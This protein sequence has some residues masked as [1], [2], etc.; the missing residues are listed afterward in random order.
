MHI[1]IRGMR[2]SAVAVAWLGRLRRAAGFGLGVG[3]VALGATL[4][5]PAQAQ[6]SAISQATQDLSCV[7][8]RYAAANGGKVP[9]CTAGEFNA[10]A[11]VEQPPG[12]ISSCAAGSTIE[13]SIITDMSGTNADR[14]SGGMY[15]GQAGN[16]PRA[17]TAP[18]AAVCSVARFP[19]SS[20]PVPGYPGTGTGFFA[21]TLAGN[22]AGSYHAGG[23]ERWQI[24]NVKVRCEAGPNGTLAIPYML[25]YSQGQL[26]VA[27]D[28]SPNLIPGT[29]AKCNA[30]TVTLKAPDGGDVKVM[31][32]VE[33]TKATSPAGAPDSFAFTAAGT[34][35]DTPSFS[36]THGQTQKVQ[37][38]LT[39]GTSTLT[40]SEALTGGWNPNATITCTAPGGGS[41]ASY[42][43]V[44]NAHRT[45]TAHLSN[46]H[47][48][49]Q[50]TITNTQL[51]MATL[52]LV[53]AMD[54]TYPG[55]A[56]PANFTLTAT[57][58]AT[59]LSGSGGASGVVP[60]G[61]YTLAESGPSG[62]TPSAWSC[63]GGALSG[64]QL[65]LSQDQNITC[66]IT[67]RHREADLQI[68]K[69]PKNGSATPGNQVVW[70]IIAQNNGP[71][72]VIGATIT[73]TLPAGIASATVA[74]VGTGGAS[75]YSAAGSGNIADT[76]N[77][78]AGS[79]VT[80]TVTANIK[81]GETANL[82]NTAVIGAPADPADPNPTNNSDTSTITLNPSADLRITK[83]QATPNPAIPGEELTWTITV[84]NLGKSSAANVTTSD[85]VDSNVTGLA[86]GGAYAGNCS[87][88]GQNVSCSF[89]TL[90]PNETRSY[91]I[92]GT[93]SASFTG[94]LGNT[95]TASST[96]P[97]PDTA[98]NTSTSTTPTN[99][100]SLIVKKVIN[101]G[102]SQVVK[103]STV[104]YA[105]SIENKGGAAAT[106]AWT[107][108]PSG[109]TITGIS[110]SITCNLSGCSNVTV[111][112]NAT[113]NFTV[114]ATVT[115]NAGDDA[116]NIARVT[117]GGCTLQNPCTAEDRKPIVAPNVQV[118]KST[119]VI[120]SVNTPASGNQYTAAYT[121]TVTNSGT[122]DGTYTLSDTPAFPSG[123]T[124]NSWQVTTNGGTLNSLMPG[125]TGGQISAANVSIA[126][127]NTTHTYAVQITFT[128]SLAATNLSCTG[129]A[130]NGA[131]NAV[132]LSGGSTGSTT[133]CGPVPA[134]VNLTLGKSASVTQAANGDS[135]TYSLT[136][137]N[138]GPVATTNP[139]T[140]VDTIPAGITVTAVTNG[141]GFSCTPSSSLP[142]VGNGVDTAI[143]CTST[144]GVA[145]GVSNAVVATLS[146]T[147]TNTQDITNRIMATSGDPRCVGVSNPCTASV[148]VQ[149]ISKPNLTVS[150][151]APAI[152]ST[153]AGGN[154]Y[155]A[156]YIVTV[157][158]TGTADGK[159]TLTDAASFATGTTLNAWAVAVVTDADPDKVGTAITPASGSGAP[160]QV[161]AN[162]VTLKAGKTHKYSVAVTFTV[163]A[164][165]MEADRVCAS[166]FEA[167]KG[168]FNTAT[169]R[170]TLTDP[171]GTNQSASGNACGD[172]PKALNLTL[173][174]TASVTEA[175]NGST[176]AYTLSASNS[177]GSA[178]TN[179]TTIVDTI[180]V[181]ITVTAV[182]NGA[183]FVCT[184]SSSLPLVGN[185][186]GTTISCVSSTGVA[187]GA[188][189]VT[190]ATLSATK[191]NTLDIT[192]HVKAT[193]GDP[194]CTGSPN[195]CT[196]S[197]EVK[198]SSAPQ[199]MVTKSNGAS[200]VTVGATVTY[201]V[202]IANSGTKDATGVTWADSAN[203]SLSVQSIAKGPVTGVGSD[204][205]SCSGVSCSGIAVAV[206]G[207]VSYTVT[208]KVTGKVGDD[209]QNTANVIGGGCTAGSEG[210]PSTPANCTST[211]TDKIVAPVA[212]APIPT[213]NE[214]AL[215]LL[216]T[217]LGLMGWRSSRRFG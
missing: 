200:N 151:A 52:T 208:A 190:V 48:G 212:V 20:V 127:N 191:T 111:P 115:G 172:L 139:T 33:V 159:Y 142:L 204:G 104:T 81:P 76:V 21:P 178:T 177:G 107:D 59:V 47:I 31:G 80:Y 187:A 138:S 175:A 141:V 150:K 88:V 105:V 75:G 26:V 171:L 40:I 34:G 85:A 96:T 154:Q 131:F 38:P 209:A 184:P 24:R 176:F 3:A 108:S 86:V 169:I 167:N 36:L 130:S 114:T 179:P 189:G 32:W 5:L 170:G 29:S 133:A 94:D 51:P 63:P 25:T 18:P 181:G 87:V 143:S 62:Y 206:N 45:I 128:T 64:N 56:I 185:G 122:A 148:P 101:G 155:T 12:G 123:V 213:L 194:R 109:L 201:T 71:D 53:K 210:A 9:N 15:F 126:K 68:T 199:L 198:D 137:S 197:V 95:A 112:A 49:A 211:D 78:P 55:S 43:T 60:P 149:D 153:V 28:A 44:D 182:A 146:V 164:T 6:Y 120:T 1:D 22:T 103:G 214:W 136:A 61:V 10:I 216:A 90:N 121:V 100:S 99:P 124:L 174:K 180:P 74:A 147:K 65:T 42:V 67:N 58:G 27:D 192:N 202:T 4:P 50:C 188:S 195:P 82:I 70:T 110:G 41:A 102:L 205:G 168:A 129:A 2:K 83:S 207:S 173:G 91:T 165:V 157:A 39:S 144:T 8:T 215:L 161:S 152:T 186:S 93:L 54:S 35:V 7:G 16:D 162:D 89:G 92:K 163:S 69:T 17:L 145:A 14:Y 156:T 30:G 23:V 97:D 57:S 135:F 98:N 193:T 46:A 117:G 118:A 11:A 116:V 217:L 125:V 183:D 132:A 166:P 77:M 13:V 203:G 140:I 37:I 66:T 106:V 160:G 158:N 72:D 196:A 19:T 84:T 134:A 119:P 79:T 73:D 113:A